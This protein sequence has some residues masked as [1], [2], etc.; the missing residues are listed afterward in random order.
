MEGISAIL[1]GAPV[2]GTGGVTRAPLGADA[3]TDATTPLIAAFVKQGY[4]GEDGV[5]KSV[6]ASDE[7]IKAWGGDTV[8]FV[9][10]EHSV[11]YSFI[12][13]ESGNAD[14]LKAIYGAENV[15]ITPPTSTKG[16]LI[17]VRTTSQMTPRAMFTLEMKDAPA[18]IREFIPVGQLTV[19]GEVNFV[20]SNVISYQVVIEAFPDEDGVKSYSWIDDGVP[21]PTIP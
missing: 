9:R 10:Q 18:T 19:S 17:E 21:T 7:K 8:K 12:F 5:T 14:V 13:L 3:P 11:S 16:G 2:T 15:I 4:V 6:D 1:T 20:H